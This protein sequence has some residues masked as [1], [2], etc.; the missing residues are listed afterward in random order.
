[1]RKAELYPCDI[2]CV[3]LGETVPEKDKLD[4]PS[5]I[6]FAEAITANIPEVDKSVLAVAVAAYIAPKVYKRVNKNR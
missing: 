3:S 4:K 2:Y 1:V 5:Q 6:Q